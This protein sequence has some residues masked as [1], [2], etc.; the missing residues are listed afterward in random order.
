MHLCGPGTEKCNKKYEFSYKEYL[1][2]KTEVFFV[3][4][5]LFNH[6]VLSTLGPL[7][8]HPNKISGYRYERM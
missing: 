1:E 8:L 6:F 2:N 3:D 5:G 7:F 4:C